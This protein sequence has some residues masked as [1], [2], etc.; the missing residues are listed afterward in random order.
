MTKLLRKNTPPQVIHI[1]YRLGIGG[2]ENGLVNLINH[3]PED[4]F[5]HGIICLKDATDFRARLK[6]GVEVYELQRREGQDFG[7]YYRLW[8]LLRRLRPEIVHTRNL[9]TV[10]CQVPAWLAGIAVRVHGE[11]GWDVFDP[12]GE[13]RKYQYLRR[14][15]KPLV[16]RYIPLS[17]HLEQYLLD[18]IKVSPARISRICNGVDTEL[19]QP[20][21]QGAAAIRDCPLSIAYPA[22]AQ[23]ASSRPRLIGTIGR[24]HGVKD[25]LTLVR[26]F[27]RLQERWPGLAE[28]SRLV[29][30][31]DGPLRAEAQALLA[32]AGLAERA[33]LPGA[34]DDVAAILRGLDLFVLPSLAEGISN[35]IL[36]AMASGL[37]VVATAVGGNPELVADGVTG[38]LVPSRDPD[39][40]A[41]ALADY[42]EHPAKMI[43]H[44]QAGLAR[45]RESFSLEVMVNRYLTVYQQ[46]LHQSS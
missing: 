1:I 37:P 31:G 30:V 44:G 21:R 11:H 19:F 32:Q 7:M 4:R 35:T 29:L 17:R 9:A 20:A 18:R 45:V 25:Q 13:N 2:L 34:R 36:E 40:L 46:L 12:Q 14:A 8:R 6:P 26:A 38:T 24:M 27:L 39:A 23:D 41:A 28:C 16:R 43:A 3:T 10:E 33:W 5:R 15:I 42:L 22:S